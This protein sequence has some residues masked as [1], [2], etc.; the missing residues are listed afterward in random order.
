MNIGDRQLNSFHLAWDE[1]EVT[2]TELRPRLARDEHDRDVLS[3]LL[4]DDGRTLDQPLTSNTTRLVY[5]APP[6]VPGSVRTVFARTRGWYEVR[7]D[8]S[9]PPEVENLQRLA[10][11]PGYIIQR[12]M[13]DYVEY[14]N[15]ALGG[16]SIW[17]RR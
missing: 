7:L 5:S 17:S 14:R 12:G 10:L 13:R 3:A 8:S 9:R 15:R 11:E 4:V 2:K 6:P 1:A 16:G